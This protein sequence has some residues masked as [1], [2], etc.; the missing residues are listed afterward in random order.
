MVNNKKLE[1]LLKVCN[2]EEY[3]IGIKDNKYTLYRDGNEYDYVQYNT[4]D[5]ALI[6]WLPH[7]E[8]IDEGENE[9]IEEI[10]YIKE[11]EKN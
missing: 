1:I 9:W 11:I 3:E 4:L 2:Y 10:N 5:E 7:M 6:D 8:A